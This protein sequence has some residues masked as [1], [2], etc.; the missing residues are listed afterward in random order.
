VTYGGYVNVSRQDIDFSSPGIMDIIINDLAAQYAIQ[1][2]AAAFTTFD[3]AAT[4]G[5]AIA[6]GPRP[7]PVDGIVV[8]AVSRSTPRRRA[9]RVFAITGRTCCRSGPVFPPY[10]PT[11]AVSPGL[12]AGSFGTGLSAASPGSRLRVGRLRHVEDSCHVDR[13]RR[14]LRRQNRSLQVVEPSVLGLQ[15][16]M[17]ATSHR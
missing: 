2:E 17:Q 13:R 8:G 10:N 14:S 16:A 15:V 5:T 4:A 1:T 7:P 6:T 3:A 9:L 12:E 11:N